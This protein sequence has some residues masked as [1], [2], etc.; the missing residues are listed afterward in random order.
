MKKKLTSEIM[1]LGKYISTSGYCSRRHA[2]DLVKQGKVHVNNRP[3]IDPS[4]V[5]KPKD[6]VTVHGNLIQP[7]KKV[8]VLYNKPKDVIC[9]LQDPEGRTT[10]ADVFAS[11]FQ[12]RL[13][14][15]GRLDRAT[16]GLIIMTNDGDLAQKLSHPSYEIPKVY[17]ITTEQTLKP[18]DV[19][20]LINGVELED[21][22][23]FVDE[24]SFPTIK[25]TISQ[26]VIHSGKNRIVRRLYEALNHTVKKLD[27]IM[28][29][30]L[31]KQKLALG[32]WRHLEQHEVQELLA[33]KPIKEYTKA[34]HDDFDEDAPVRSSKPKAPKA[35][36]PKKAHSSIPKG[37]PEYADV[38]EDSKIIGY[39]S[40]TG[41]VH[42]GGRRAQQRASMKR[43]EQ[44]ADQEDAQRTSGRPTA[45]AR[46]YAKSSS[47]SYHRKPA[48]HRPEGPTRYQEQD[49]DD[50]DD[51]NDAA[52]QPRSRR[53]S[54]GFDSRPADERPTRRS[55][56]A[57][58]PRSDDRSW[59]HDDRPRRN[60]R[61]DDRS[62]ENFERPR[63]TS[64]SE[65]EGSRPA[66]RR[67]TSFKPRTTRDRD[68]RPAKRNERSE[69][70]TGSKAPKR[71]GRPVSSARNSATNRWKKKK[72][73]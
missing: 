72:S 6:V 18:Y 44:Q 50:Y 31:T 38:A 11:E 24:I 4:Y 40:K 29:A 61:N 49:F 33:I 73:E 62:S 66:S 22:L 23:M 37:F 20:Q 34:D 2:V 65:D 48:Y 53:S 7:A 12:E 28:F 35:A 70:R 36:T 63:R 47:S 19:Q 60:E 39:Q 25:R 5:V 15:I 56:T 68:E 3:Q 54:T 64:R 59:Q 51:R 46:S 69:S 13:Y 8:Y 71:S 42:V 26:V 21:G 45:G 14:P 41:K 43:Q 55:S 1:Y 32:A 16:T 30:G 17:Q 10:I 52:P 67:S 27:R 57:R 58:A 9:T